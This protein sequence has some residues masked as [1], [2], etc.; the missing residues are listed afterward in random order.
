[1]L[2]NLL[3]QQ[4]NDESLNIDI[5]GQGPYNVAGSLA[6]EDIENQVRNSLNFQSS[7][8]ILSPV[9][10]EADSDRKHHKKIVRKDVE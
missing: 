10:N 2:A 6:L 7:S 5:G 9:L 1:M 4:R 3:D 8:Q